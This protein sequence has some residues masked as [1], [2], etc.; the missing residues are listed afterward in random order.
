[1]LSRMRHSTVVVFGQGNEDWLLLS[2]CATAGIAR[3]TN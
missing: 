2:L 3:K 1:M